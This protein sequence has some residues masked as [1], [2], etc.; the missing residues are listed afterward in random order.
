MYPPDSTTVLAICSAPLE[1][2]R[3]ASPPET[4]VICVC[5]LPE[6]APILLSSEDEVL[7]IAPESKLEVLVIRAA[8][9]PEAAVILSSSADDTGATMFS[10]MPPEPSAPWSSRL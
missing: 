10:R 4:A 6:A 2:G 8:R 5:N 3:C 1:V 7:T 9:L